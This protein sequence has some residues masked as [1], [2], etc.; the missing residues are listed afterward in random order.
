MRKPKLRELKEA[1]RALLFG[2]YTARELPDAD[3]NYRGEGQFDE[4][5][6]VACGGCAQV[7]PANAI[8]VIDKR[9]ADPPVREIR[10]Y[11]DRCVFC[12]AC[13][14]ECLTQG[15][16]HLTPEYDLACFDRDDCIVSIEKPLV[17]C[18]MCGAIIGTQAHLRWVAQQV[19]ARRFAN[20]TLALTLEPRPT[21]EPIPERDK[22]L[23]PDRSDILRVLCPTC[24]RVVI[25]TEVW[26]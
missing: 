8:E 24:R 19:G 4:D 18:E 23:P 6:C 22:S 17:L 1:V 2:P 13:E 5:K 9:D 20:P 11:H 26:G 21:L 16:V 10:R 15:G 25:L 3:P 7:C 14:Q 12:G